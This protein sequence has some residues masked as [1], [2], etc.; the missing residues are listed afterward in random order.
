MPR[1]TPRQMSLFGDDDQPQT[2]PKQA[3]SDARPLPLII[4]D[5]WGFPLQHHVVD[6][7]DYYAVQD[8]LRGVMQKTDVASD[9]KHLQKNHGHTLIGVQSMA[10]RRS[11]GRVY[12]MP[13]APV[14]DLWRIVQRMDAKTGIRN[15]VLEYLVKSGVKM[16][17][18]RLDPE[19]A[20]SD[21]IDSG[22]WHDKDAAWKEARLL[23]VIARKDLTDAMRDVIFNMPDSFYGQS[24]DMM[25]K[26]L[27]E[28]TTAQLR[29]ELG[30]TNSKG[31]T[32]DRFGT[33]ALIYV[34]L[35]EMLIA[36]RL[37]EQTMIPVSMATDI[38][39]EIA[40]MIKAQADA[41]SNALG[42][43]LVTSRPRLTDG[44]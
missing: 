32:R 4:A 13:F 5:K 6:G 34:R 36:D 1:N 44:K 33:Y 40:K 8:W 37:R 17:E 3:V 15:A 2:N 39:Y 35:T 25:Y 43:D 19:Q 30:F 10:Y 41:T 42:I 24:T 16:D 7:V 21:A 31:N 27:W 18:Y 22:V 23:G 14:S 12:Q 11:N 9:W 20:V 38:V 29:G 26:T 28:R